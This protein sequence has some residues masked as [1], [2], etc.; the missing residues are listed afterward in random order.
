MPLADKAYIE[1]RH[2]QKREAGSLY[3]RRGSRGDS[4][5]KIAKSTVKN[6]FPVIN[7]RYKEELFVT[8]VDGKGQS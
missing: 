3:F 1:T 5:F 6:F 8:C 4:F 7:V 2:I